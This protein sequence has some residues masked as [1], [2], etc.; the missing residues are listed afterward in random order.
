MKEKRRS[1]LFLD[2]ILYKTFGK[3]ILAQTWPHQASP[4]SIW[5]YWGLILQW[6]M[7]CISVSLP[8]EGAFPISQHYQTNGTVAK[9][10]AAISCQNTTFHIHTG[11]VHSQARH[12]IDSAWRQQKL[13]RESEPSQEASLIP[14]RK[15]HTMRTGGS[16]PHPLP[17]LCPS[18]RFSEDTLYAD[19]SRT[20][21]PC[22]LSC[23]W[24][25]IQQQKQFKRETVLAN[26]VRV[27]STWVRSH[28]GRRLRQQKCYITLRKSQKDGYLCSTDLFRIPAQRMVP[29]ARSREQR[30]EGLSMSINPSLGLINL[31]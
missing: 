21:C 11:N 27:Q 14:T 2:L 15:L 31:N 18:L 30:R 6:Q 12:G 4:G 19:T 20:S 25:N 29:P 16:S 24:D 17:A 13:R 5:I 3:G 8:N 9:N 10:Q 7:K 23:C 28:G 1:S 26:S 22:Y